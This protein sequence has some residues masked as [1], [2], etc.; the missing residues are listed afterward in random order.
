MNFKAFRTP[1]QDII[2]SCF[3]PALF[4]SGQLS[5]GEWKGPL[6]TGYQ[7]ITGP[8]K[9]TKTYI[10]EG[11]MQ[12]SHLKNLARHH[13]TLRHKSST[14][15]YSFDIYNLLTMVE[16][17]SVNDNFDVIILDIQCTLHYIVLYHRWVCRARSQL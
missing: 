8:H 2:H 3:K 5:P 11:S 9:D 15:K 12:T 4:F 16:V 7:S 13:L 10:H 6:Q 17:F 1:L 14:F